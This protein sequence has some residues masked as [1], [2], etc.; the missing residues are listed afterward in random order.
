M[1][2][3]RGTEDEFDVPSCYTDLHVIGYGTY[4]EVREAKVVEGATRPDNAYFLR[5][6]PGKMVAIKRL[7]RDLVYRDSYHAKKVFREITLLKQLIHENVVKLVDLY[8]SDARDI[9]IITEKMDC[10]LSNILIPSFEMND[11][12]VQYILY[13]IMRGLKYIHSAGVI[14][15]DLKPSNILL[16]S[17]LDARICDFGLARS[18]SQTTLATGYVTTRWYRAPEVMLTWRHYT[19]AL[20]MWS[21][22]CIFGEMLNKVRNYITATSRDPN[23]G[24]VTPLYALFPAESHVD[25]L[26]KIMM[27]VGPPPPEVVEAT[28]DS[29][30][31]VFLRDKVE[32]L[33]ESASSIEQ[34]F[35]NVDSTATSMIV[36][37]LNFNPAHRFHAAHALEHP[38]LSKYHE[39]SE[40]HVRTE[41]NRDFEL[42][43]LSLDNW[44]RYIAREEVN[45]HQVDSGEFVPDP[46]THVHAAVHN[47]LQQPRTNAL[48]MPDFGPSVPSDYS[49]DEALRDFE[50]M[51]AQMQLEDPGST[52][53]LDLPDVGE[54]PQGPSEQFALDLPDRMPSLALE[55]ELMSLEDDR[56]YLQDQLTDDAVADPSRLL[57][58]LSEVD[59]ELELA[60][61]RTHHDTT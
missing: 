15:R 34:Y 43:E 48:P 51:T 17:S 3:S 30:I 45:M 61:Q 11:A 60:Q 26:E 57:V 44:G 46:N 19:E 40:E 54:A 33:R 41:I 58:G 23:T 55:N 42:I 56:R 16:N 36:G 18:S 27:I 8:I 52:N 28:T 6:E 39:P 47:P 10:D 25:H 50:A 31:A 2:D 20:D 59:A 29:H 35:S 49:L 7:K 32:Q 4:G 38:Y 22:G 37:L 1:G 24:E 53:L 9:Y 14:H 21:V 5:L 12:M 13:G